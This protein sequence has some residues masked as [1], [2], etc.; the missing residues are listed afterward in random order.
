M[1]RDDFHLLFQTSV[2]VLL[3]S[4]LRSLG[5]SL[6]DLSGLG[7]SQAGVL[8]H[9]FFHSLRFLYEMECRRR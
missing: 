8:W 6:A 3:K 9:Q 1:T 4:F 5:F 7:N 2:V